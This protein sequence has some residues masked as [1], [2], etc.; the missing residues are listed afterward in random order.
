VTESRGATLIA[1]D[2]EV[3]FPAN[4][5]EIVILREVGFS[6][7]PG[8]ITGVIGETGAGKSMAA[9]GLLDLVPS[10]GQVTRG[11]VLLDGEELLFQSEAHRRRLRGRRIA[12]VGQNPRAAMHPM[13]RVGRQIA[14]AYLAHHDVSRSEANEKATEALREVRLPDPEELFARY[15]HELSGGMAQR[16]LIALAMVNDPSVLIADE[17]TTGLDA[18]TQVEILDLMTTLTVEHD[19]AVMLVT[20]DLGVVANY[21]ARAV[22]M[23]AGEVV[24]SGRTEQILGHPVHPYTQALVGSM[25]GRREGSSASRGG[26]PD[27]RS[28][29]QGCQFAY[30]C[31]MVEQRCEERGIPLV[32]RPDGQAARCVV[33]EQSRQEV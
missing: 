25:L 33:A 7:H 2:L 30:R 9:W 28:R 4:R 31:P 22:V 26:P 13:V 3:R 14:N 6:L 16:V 29:P 10:P 1:K 24:E 27:L 12:I 15:P 8:E 17:P 11:S 23:F 32:V 21:T 19:S 18:T 20:H 5:G